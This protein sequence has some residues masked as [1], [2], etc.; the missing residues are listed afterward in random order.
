L[1]SL[2]KPTRVIID[3]KV[4]EINPLTANLD[5]KARDLDEN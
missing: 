5:E 2:A 3:K 1:G 4:I